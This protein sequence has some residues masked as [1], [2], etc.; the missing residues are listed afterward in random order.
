MPQGFTS[1]GSDFFFLF[2]SIFST[3]KMLIIRV[4]SG[5]GRGGGGVP[6]SFPPA[7]APAMVGIRTM[8][9]YDEN[10]KKSSHNASSQQHTCVRR[11][12]ECEVVPVMNHRSKKL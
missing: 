7:F 2:L 1:I 12:K 9:Y 6:H 4:A 11:E 8:Y 5:G 10:H 3:E